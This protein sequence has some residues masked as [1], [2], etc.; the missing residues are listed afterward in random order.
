MSSD[1][2]CNMLND[3]GNGHNI[4]GKK[5]EAA[6]MNLSGKKVTYGFGHKK[7]DGHF[8]HV[9]E[10]KQLVKIVYICDWLDYHGFERP[11]WKP[12]V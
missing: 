1:E 9:W 6:Q 5:I 7:N 2:F 3:T 8:S 12:Q 10:F 11:K 4:E